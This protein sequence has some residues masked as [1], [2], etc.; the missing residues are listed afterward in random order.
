MK[1]ILIAILGLSIFGCSDPD[2]GP[3]EFSDNMGSKM[4]ASR[5]W[6]ETDGVDLVDSGSQKIERVGEVSTKAATKTKNTLESVGEASIIVGSA[7]TS[8]IKAIGDGIIKVKE[9]EEAYKKE[10]PEKY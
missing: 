9:E 2:G 3:S 5:K 7:I 1:Y 6:A 8:S 10:H 4:D